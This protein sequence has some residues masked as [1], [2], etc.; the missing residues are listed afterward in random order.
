M[1]KLIDK[2]FSS[3]SFDFA[4][5]LYAGVITLLYGTSKALGFQFQY[6]NKADLHVKDLSGFELTW[7][8]FGYSY[9]YTLFIAFCQICGALLLF[10]NK[11]KLVGAAILYPITLNIILIDIFYKVPYGALGN[12][13]TIFLCLTVTIFNGRHLFKHLLYSASEQKSILTDKSKILLLI[14][15]F[16]IGFL[17]LTMVINSILGHYLL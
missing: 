16:F 3:F 15:L 10:Y 14:I 12:A 11:T 6:S 5:R 13:I 9:P 4:T 8:F 7:I 2:Y 17:G 1:N